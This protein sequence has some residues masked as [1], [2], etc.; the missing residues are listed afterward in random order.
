MIRVLYGLQAN[1]FG[2]GFRRKVPNPY[3][4]TRVLTRC[5]IATMDTWASR[6]ILG[7]AVWRSNPPSGVRRDFIDR[8]CATRSHLPRHVPARK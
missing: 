2:S 8:P 4:A 7:L 5:A 3:V 6:V 1:R